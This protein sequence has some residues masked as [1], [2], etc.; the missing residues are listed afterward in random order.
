MT[1]KHIAKPYAQVTW[2]IDD[3]TEEF[4][5]TNHQAA[6]VLGTY[7]SDIQGAMTEAGW[8]AISV[9]VAK[10]LRE[11]ESVANPTGSNHQP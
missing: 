5:L 10:F 2:L 11:N 4:G 7:E 1:Q 6:E 9:F 3:L 8:N